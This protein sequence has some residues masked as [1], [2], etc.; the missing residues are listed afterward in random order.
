MYDW[1]EQQTGL[2]AAYVGELVSVSVDSGLTLTNGEPL[3]I[4][5]S[6]SLKIIIR[7]A[8]AES[9]G[10]IAEAVK[11][12]MEQQ[13]GNLN[14]RLGSHELVLL[15]GSVWQHNEHGCD[16]STDSLQK[17]DLWL[18]NNHCRCKSSIFR[19][20]KQYYTLLMKENGLE[21]TTD[22]EQSI[23][24]EEQLV[25]ENPAVS[26]KYVVLGAVLFALYIC[27]G[28]VYGVYF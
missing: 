28:P 19:R 17:F 27:C 14:T 13:Q 5:G 8:D 23:V 22:A 26:K 20:P 16:E 12:Y 3:T 7:G 11:T 10:K 4:G 2:E 21:D 9:C 24:E 15:S 25:P 1:I 18:G 6:D